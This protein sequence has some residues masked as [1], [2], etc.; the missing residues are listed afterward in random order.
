MKVVTLITSSNRNGFTK[1]I[2]DSLTSGIEDAEGTNEVLFFAD[3]DIK[4]CLGC[5][6]C[7]E[8]NGC[9]LDDDFNDII[10]KIKDAD[11]FIFTAPIFWNDIAGHSKLFLDRLSSLSY[12]PELMMDSKCCLILTHFSKNINSFV[13]ENTHRCLASANFKVNKIL[14]VGNLMDHRVLDQFEL[15]EYE[16]IGFELEEYEVIPHKL[17]L[18]S[19]TL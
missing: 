15:E 14:D 17:D 18:E 11:Y 16:D 8:G 7:K 6:K 2:V 12:S 1:Q 3:Y 9:I 10:K 4:F 5:G 13:I 19:A